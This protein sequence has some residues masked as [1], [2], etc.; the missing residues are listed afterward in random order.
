M[1]CR[2]RCSNGGQRE[3]SST[4]SV[5]WA[6]CGKDAMCESMDTCLFFTRFYPPIDHA[7]QHV[8][9]Y[10][11]ASQDYIVELAQVK[12]CYQGLFGTGPQLADFDLAKFIGNC[13]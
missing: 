13:L 6:F 12:F 10:G 5:A 9:R 8:Q 7:L 11:P 4:E 3:E 2:S 1:S